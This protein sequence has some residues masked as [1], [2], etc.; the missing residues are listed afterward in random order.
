MNPDR[1]KEAK[2][3]PFFP[4]QPFI[5]PTGILLGLHLPPFPGNI[6]ETKFQS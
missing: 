3:F 4:G 6:F 2:W 1:P 5:Q